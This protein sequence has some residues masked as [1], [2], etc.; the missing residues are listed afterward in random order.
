MKTRLSTRD[1]FGEIRVI[2]QSRGMRNPRN[3]RAESGKYMLIY[4][5][6]GF[7]D[8]GRLGEQASTGFSEIGI[9]YRWVTQQRVPRRRASH[10]SHFLVQKI[11]GRDR[12]P[13]IFHTD[14]DSWG[15]FTALKLVM[16]KRHLYIVLYQKM[17]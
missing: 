12:N 2:I 13:F 6:L 17:G 4:I 10:F 3:R 14:E 7:L 1:I 9:S 16:E 11:D 15:F 8:R 5:T